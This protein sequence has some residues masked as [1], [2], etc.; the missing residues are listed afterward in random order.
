MPSSVAPGTAA[1]FAT[2]AAESNDCTDAGS[3]VM[4]E[5][6]SE[7]PPQAAK[8]MQSEIVLSDMKR[9]CSAVGVIIG[10]Q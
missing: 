5:G 1:T 6:S 4:S 3:S 8:E 7:P 10:G 2:T 9:G